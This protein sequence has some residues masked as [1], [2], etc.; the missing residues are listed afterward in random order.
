MPQRGVYIVK[1]GI[2]KTK[3]MALKMP[4]SGAQKMGFDVFKFYEMDPWL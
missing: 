3:K 1:I 4:K 2:L